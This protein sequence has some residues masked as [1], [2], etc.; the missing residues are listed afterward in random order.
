MS[1]IKK[2]EAAVEVISH[3]VTP[4]T[5]NTDARAYARLGWFIVLAG[6]VG[7]LVW[8]SFAPLDKGSPLSGT[9]MKEGNRKAVQHLQG[10]IVQDIL[11][12]D[13]DHVEVGQ[14]LVRMNPVQFRSALDIT[15]V[16]YISARV[17]EARLEAELA[18]KQSVVLPD[19][20]REFKDNVHTVDALALQNQLIAS[21]RLSLQNE[22]ST[23]D[24]SIAGL[25]AQIKGVDESR[26][27]KRAQLTMMKEQVDSMAE[28]AK[29]GFVARNR[30]LELK[31][32][33][34][35]LL[36]A[37]AE[38][39]GT[40]GRVERQV[41]ETA[42]RKM[43]RNSEY[44]KEVRTQLTDARKEAESLQG[45]LVSQQFD[46]GSVELKAPVAGVVVGSNVFTKGGVVSGGAKLM[47]IV[48]DDD[49][50]VVEGQLAINLIDRI[51]VGLPVEMSFS[52]FNT[53]ST[54][55]IPGTVV[56]V[57]ADRTVD[58]RT[59]AS[60]YKVRARVT[61]EGLK[62]IAAKK[63]DVVSGMPVDM[64]VKT[65]ER[66]MMS[67]LLKPVFDRAKS[68]MTEE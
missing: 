48:P 9:V 41:T 8:A 31:R 24:E 64:F 62:L 40:L 52:A 57:A 26:N 56:T 68:S 66:T 14:V 32:G 47:E 21:R 17:T 13:G 42:M 67:Y 6:V 19:T 51:H 23:L 49:A 59:G 33:Y 29:D 45:R 28:L 5:V 15:Q 25:R 58:E 65:G 39:S 38:D 61:P 3:D 43:L 36:G 30:Y 53:N 11:V 1:I 54:P 22:L 10:G 27:S 37:I 16:Q 20:L 46:Y 34:E 60:Y 44:Q 2:Q 4:L 35:Q 7:F 50:L 63:L 12:K 18:G 55:H